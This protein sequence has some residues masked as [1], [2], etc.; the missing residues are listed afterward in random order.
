M[1]GKKTALASK[2]QSFVSLPDIFAITSTKIPKYKDIW[3]VCRV[4]IVI[5]GV[6][7]L[8][9]GICQNEIRTRESDSFIGE[10]WKQVGKLIK[11][12]R[13]KK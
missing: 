7:N 8:I 9:R 10:G 1:Q 2:Y 3:M 5:N 12:L 4:C 11:L 6:F 13:T